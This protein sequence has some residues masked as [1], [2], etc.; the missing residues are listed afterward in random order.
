LFERVLIKII[1][2]FLE[3]FEVLFLVKI[4]KFFNKTRRPHQG[5]QLFC[6]MGN[7]KIRC[8][9]F[10]LERLVEKTYCGDNRVIFYGVFIE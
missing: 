1:F 6:L 8:F 2:V 3:I 9:L 10:E 4:L 7:W 5:L